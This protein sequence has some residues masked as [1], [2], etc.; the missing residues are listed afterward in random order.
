MN[1]LVDLIDLIM[2]NNGKFP[3]LKKKNPIW[4]GQSLYNEKNSQ[5]FLE[6]VASGNCVLNRNGL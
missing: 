4:N 3:F 1:S 2:L 6:G 5:S